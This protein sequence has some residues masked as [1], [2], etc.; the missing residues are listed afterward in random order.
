MPAAGAA[1]VVGQRLLPADPSHHVFA[2][3]GIGWHAAG[4]GR[5]LIFVSPCPPRLPSRF[6]S[7]A[8]GAHVYGEPIFSAAHS[9]GGVAAAWASIGGFD[10]GKFA[11]RGGVYDWGQGGERLEEQLVH[12]Q[13]GGA[14]G[15]G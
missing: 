8:T 3:A 12:Q 1:G 4:P 5:L 14:M 11:A 9:E 2:A 15:L 7:N 13:V 10:S 6:F